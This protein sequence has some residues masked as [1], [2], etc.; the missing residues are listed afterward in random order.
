VQLLGV[1]TG[2][3]FT[4][5]VVILADGSL[6]LGK[7]LSTP[8]ALERGVV[9]SIEAAAADLHRTAADVLATTDFVA[10][11]TTAGLNALLTGNGARK[12]LLTTQGFEAT[13]PMARANTVRGIDERFKTEA[14]RWDRPFSSAAS[15]SRAWSSGSTPTA[16]S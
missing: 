5:S 14:I 2:G 3:T 11:G 4:D 15:G 16:R 7:A 8:G 6:G 1:D 12:G 9:A 13:I 10:H